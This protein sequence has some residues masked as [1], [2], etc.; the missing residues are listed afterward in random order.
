MDYS[1]ATVVTYIQKNVYKK[2][3]KIPLVFDIIL[4]K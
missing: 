3:V 2:N 1:L 4:K